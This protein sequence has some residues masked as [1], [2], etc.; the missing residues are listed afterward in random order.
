MDAQCRS[1]HR[2]GREV[3]PATY[4]QDAQGRAVLDP[5]RDAQYTR[6]L[7]EEICK[8]YARDMVVMS[9][10]LVAAACF[11]RLRK[12]APAS[13]LF[14][15]LR[16]RDSVVVP[17]DELAADVLALKGRLLDLERRGAVA[18]SD[19]LRGASGGDIV[20]RAMRA[21][22]GYHDT[23]VLAARR[24]GI[25]L[26]DTNLLFYYQNRLAAHGLAW[27]VIAPP[28]DVPR[29]LGR[30]TEPPA[31]PA[32]PEAPPPP[33]ATPTVAA[34]GATAPVESGGGNAS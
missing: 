19:F 15:V 25:A 1:F 18:V 11:A 14:T 23:P 20:E 22:A 9:T 8:S 7:G 30:A 12:A 28:G 5:V 17:R 3:N 2:R 21:F 32:H 29:V 10:H 4:V 34:K 31:Y 26:C 13:D 6:E 33:A 16:Q 24:D 27:D